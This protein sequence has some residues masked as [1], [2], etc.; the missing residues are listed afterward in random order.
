M[1]NKNV[2]TEE[3]KPIAGYEGL[4]EVSNLGRV[5][6]LKRNNTLGKT[7]KPLT[8]RDGYYQITLS[9]NN[10]RVTKKVHRLVAI[11]FIENPNNYPVIN[12]KDENKQN[13][14][15]ENLEWCTVKYNTNYNGMAHRRMIH[16]RKPLVAIKGEEILKFESVFDASQ[17]LGVSHSN[18]SNCLHG[19]KGHKT[20]KGYTFEFI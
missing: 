18:I 13:N 3:W 12:H 15:V 16:R 6:S 9:K 2:I 17:K 10:V 5:R 19:K 7:L 8:D 14:C 4:Y 1:D 20:L 11:A